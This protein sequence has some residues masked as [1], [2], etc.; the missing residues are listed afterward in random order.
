MRPGSCGSGPHACTRGRSPRQRDDREVAV[1]GGEEQQLV[2]RRG[3]AAVGRRLARSR[4]ASVHAAAQVRGAHRG[5]DLLGLPAEPAHLGGLTG[6]R[7]PWTW[8]RGR[9]FRGGTGLRA[10]AGPSCGLLDRLRRAPLRRRARRLPRCRTANGACRRRR[11]R[12]V[13]GRRTLRGGGLRGRAAGARLGDGEV[14]P[15]R[16]LGGFRP[17]REG[18]GRAFGGGGELG[19]PGRCARGRGLG[20]GHASAGEERGEE[21]DHRS[22]GVHGAHAARAGPGPA[23]RTDR[24]H[25]DE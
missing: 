23:R 3:H 11:G 10:G 8:T 15:G 7:L 21:S 24:I 18:G 12:A 17:C 13:R 9:L 2:R 22:A 6:H 1:A 19:G 20:D 5:A 25:R 4:S 16:G 14:L